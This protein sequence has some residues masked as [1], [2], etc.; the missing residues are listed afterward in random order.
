MTHSIY[1]NDPNGYGVEV[2]Y[3]LPREVWGHDID[4]ALNHA[5]VRDADN[6]LVDDTDYPSEFK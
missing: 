5:V 3:D 2:L 1:I 4:G 6:P